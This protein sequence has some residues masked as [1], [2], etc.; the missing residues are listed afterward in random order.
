MSS[1]K[2]VKE[3]LKKIL[4]M[5]D[6]NSKDDGYIRIKGQ[7]YYRV[8]INTEFPVYYS[9]IYYVDKEGIPRVFTKSQNSSGTSYRGYINP[10]GILA[11]PGRLPGLDREY[12]TSWVGDGKDD[13]VISST[14]KSMTCKVIFDS[15]GS[16]ESGQYTISED[17]GRIY[18][19]RQ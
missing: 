8:Q 17:N 1:E 15:E 5:K 2:P 19:S 16:V 12:L 7:I 4:E 14:Q 9:N 3:D 13:R 11:L 6:V 10:D 18:W